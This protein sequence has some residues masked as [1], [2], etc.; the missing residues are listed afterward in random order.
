VSNIANLLSAT[1]ADTVK[2]IGTAI[3]S[4]QLDVKVTGTTTDSATNTSL[5]V[6][7]LVNVDG[8]TTTYIPDGASGNTRFSFVA[9]TDSKIVKDNLTGL[10]WESQYP[11]ASATT[12]TW[13][14][15]K[16]QCASLN[17][18]GQTPGS[19]RLPDYTEL[20]SIIDY[21]KSWGPFI[22]T[23]FFA[24]QSFFHWTSTTY[25]SNTNSAWIMNFND[26]TS[27]STAKTSA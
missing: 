7:L 10:E 14:T 13:A 6:N 18:L 17:I 26:G 20:Q 1:G 12:Y 16:S 22:N 5:V 11:V 15:A 9:G 24:S 4:N 27:S 19:W 21:S 3:A 2:S 8:S 25:N 23:A